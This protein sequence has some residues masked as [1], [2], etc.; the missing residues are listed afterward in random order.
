MCV[1][2]FCVV[3]LGVGTV[4]SCAEAACWH[5]AGTGGDPR[6]STHRSQ[7]WNCRLSHCSWSAKYIQVIDVM[8]DRGYS[9]MAETV[10]LPS[11]GFVG[12]WVCRNVE[13]GKTLLFS[14]C[15]SLRRNFDRNPDF[16]VIL[17]MCISVCRLFLLG[18]CMP[19]VHLAASSKLWKEHHKTEER[20][21][22]QPVGKS[23]NLGRSS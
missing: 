22:L 20:N 4:Y 13:M 14:A 5:W 9:T 7:S 3:T 18:E 15:G 10:P 23:R 21:S 16:V 12:W 11:P 6:C 19:L 1:S 8:T 17:N 2:W